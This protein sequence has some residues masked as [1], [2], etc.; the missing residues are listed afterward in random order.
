MSAVAHLEIV[1]QDTKPPYSCE[2]VYATQ[3]LVDR[4]LSYN[5]RNRPKKDGYLHRLTACV[6]NG[7]WFASPDAIAVSSSGILLNGQHRLESI[8][9]AGYPQVALLIV[10][11]LPDSSMAI[12]DRGVGRTMRDTVSLLLNS[13]VGARLVAALNWFYRIRTDQISATSVDCDPNILLEYMETHKEIIDELMPIIGRQRAPITAA[14][15]DY[16]TA[17]QVM[18]LEFARQIAYGEGLTKSDPAYRVREAIKKWKGGGNT[19]QKQNYELVV[20]AINKHRSGK[21]V[22]RLH[23][24]PSTSR[25]I[26][27]E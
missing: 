2:W 7:R 15:F 17:D 19:I 5:T 26:H 10:A 25:A 16:A 18:A 12:I 27:D 1:K 22:K 23:A 6:K 3:E 11:G 13:T 20:A 24:I 9:A 14:I 21:K 8:K 4:L